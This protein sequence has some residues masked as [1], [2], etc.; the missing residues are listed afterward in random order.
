MQ[1]LINFIPNP[2]VT[3]GII[4]LLLGLIYRVLIKELLKQIV[5]AIFSSA[6]SAKTDRVTFQLRKAFCNFQIEYA[7]FHFDLTQKHLQLKSAVSI[8]K[9]SADQSLAKN[10]EEVKR[11]FKELNEILDFD[12]SKLLGGI[13]EHI[14]DY[15]LK[16]RYSSRLPRVY[17]HIQNDENKLIN[18]LPDGDYTDEP[19]DP[20]DY[21]IFSKVIA[22]GTPY[23]DNNIIFT[24]LKDSEY[25]HAGLDI[26][27]INQT[28]GLYS[29]KVWKKRIPQRIYR[30]FSG[31]PDLDRNWK[32]CFKSNK[33]TIDNSYKSHLAIP[34]TF[35]AHAVKSKLN[36]GFVNLLQLREDGRT[37]LGIIIIDH[38]DT[39]YFDHNDVLEP[40]NI[41]VNV[42]YQFADLISLLIVLK[43][44]FSIGSKTYKECLEVYGNE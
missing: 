1:N 29:W 2:L 36:K 32:R 14:K 9:K 7:S 37:I 8:Q 18:L 31:K 15:F 33:L 35:R 39:H 43:L 38:T 4:L 19:K 28:M 13:T 40:K 27:K 17:I 12:Y 10:N 21:T 20:E 16:T 42:M 22:S 30:L 26:L 41:D 34:I 3:G 11:L 25:K 6:I 44:N 24:A 23:L 5:A